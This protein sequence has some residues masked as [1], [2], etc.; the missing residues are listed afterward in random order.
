MFQNLNENDL[1][2]SVLSSFDEKMIGSAMKIRKEDEQT[3]QSLSVRS[4]FIYFHFIYTYSR[5]CPAPAPVNTKMQSPSLELF[6]MKNPIIQYEQIS[7][8]LLFG[9]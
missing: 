5:G 8:L 4:F 7:L 3:F 9:S 2:Q 6:V 1:V